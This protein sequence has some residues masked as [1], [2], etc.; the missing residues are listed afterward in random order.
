MI[1]GVGIDVVDIYRF[2][3]IIKQGDEQFIR[4]IFT[5]REIM[6]SKEKKNRAEYFAAIF[7]VKEAILK[8]LGCGLSIGFVWRDIQVRN[9]EKPGLITELSGKTKALAGSLSITK[10]IPAVTTDNHN[11]TAMAILEKNS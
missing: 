7:A 9:A 11:V 1:L 5:N 4:E 2:E 3:D 8:A 10:I 6:I